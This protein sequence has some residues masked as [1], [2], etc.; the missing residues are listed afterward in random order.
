MMF[1]NRID[2]YQKRDKNERNGSVHHDFGNEDQ[3]FVEKCYPEDCF[4]MLLILTVSEAFRE[5]S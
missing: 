5:K 4:A 1:I 3:S 2:F